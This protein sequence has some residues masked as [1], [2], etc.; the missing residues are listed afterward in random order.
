MEVK[1]MT[2]AINQSPM[3]QPVPLRAN[4]SGLILSR[5]WVIPTNDQVRLL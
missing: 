5:V 4:L 1:A 2:D 3:Y